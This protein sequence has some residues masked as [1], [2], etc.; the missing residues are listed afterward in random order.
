MA[1]TRVDGTFLWFEKR[2]HGPNVA[3]LH[4]FP[5]DRRIWSDQ[6]DALSAKFSVCTPDLR[7][8]GRS[9]CDQPFTIASL[10]DD[11]HELL[12]QNGALP[13]V[14]GGLSMGGYVSLA[15]AAK[16]A[17]DLSGLIL[18]DTKAEADSPQ[19]KE[20]R[21]K[22]IEMAK[23]GG[24]SAVAEAMLPRL[25][26]PNSSPE[27]VK[28]LQSIMLDCP[29]LTIQH[30]LAAMRDREDYTPLLEKL[31]IPVHVIV[32]E[33]DAISPPSVAE[34]MFKRCRRGS[35]TVIAGAGHL[36]PIEAPQ[37]VSKAIEEFAS[38]C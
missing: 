13:C 24:T 7:G 29:A 15:F 5:L 10:A 21:E 23:T 31:Q 6:F 30:A 22:M 1:L 18:I 11:V 35:M 26:A 17:A 12:K 33:H 14:L 19:A 28:R 9:I 32:G 16:Y 20:G 8:F 37:A 38:K 27:V 34:Q 3:L 36:T 25:M 2:G 4:G